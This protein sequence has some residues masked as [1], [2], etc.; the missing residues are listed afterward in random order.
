[1]QSGKLL[2]ATTETGCVRAYKFPMT[3]DFS[4]LRCH[5]SAISCMRLLF[6][7]SLLF[8]AGNDGSIFMFDVRQELKG[9]A[10]LKRDNDKLPFADEV[11]VTKSDLEE[12]K[13]RCDLTS[14]SSLLAC[15]FP[16]VADLASFV[17]AALYKLP[18]CCFVQ[19]RARRVT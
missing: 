7:E 9:A 3:G 6:D 17:L 1:M 14:C 2:L 5:S 15:R 10:A 12:R 11:M 13:A 16:P 8:T 18:D 4:E 19:L